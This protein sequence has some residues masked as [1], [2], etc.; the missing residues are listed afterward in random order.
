MFER[1]LKR[2]SVVMFGATREN[3]GSRGICNEWPHRINVFMLSAAGRMS[4]IQS[5][6]CIPSKMQKYAISSSKVC[7]T[8][9]G[10]CKAVA[11]DLDQA[12]ASNRSVFDKLGQGGAQVVI[13]SRDTWSEAIE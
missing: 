10:N 1:R 3:R 9:S 13:T 8:M 12:S 4:E 5:A 11:G 7:S 2:G 6:R